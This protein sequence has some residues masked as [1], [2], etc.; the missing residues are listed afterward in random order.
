MRRRIADCGD[1]V[2]LLWHI[3]GEFDAILDEDLLQYCRRFVGREPFHLILVHTAFF[4][5]SVDA[6]V[7]CDKAAHV[8]TILLIFVLFLVRVARAEQE[9]MIV[10]RLLVLVEIRQPLDGGDSVE[11]CVRC[12]LGVRVCQTVTDR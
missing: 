11:H 8:E 4:H 10:Y 6:L 7:R 1:I 3:P 12:V 5:L 9:L 2:R